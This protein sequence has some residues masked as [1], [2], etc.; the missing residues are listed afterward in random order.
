MGGRWVV[1]SPYLHRQSDVLLY[2]LRVYVD[3]ALCLL[4]CL[5]D[6]CLFSAVDMSSCLHAPSPPFC[7][8]KQCEKTNFFLSCV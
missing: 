2:S 7:L 3:R 5:V 6:I 1:S 4:V 8:Q